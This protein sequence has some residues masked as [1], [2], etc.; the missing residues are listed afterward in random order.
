MVN[1]RAIFKVGQ[2]KGWTISL[3][4][5]VSLTSLNQILLDKHYFFSL[6]GHHM[7]M[8]YSNYHF[9]LFRQVFHLEW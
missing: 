5:Y 8:N 2:G 4:I 6:L 1:V 9:H 3:S 7:C